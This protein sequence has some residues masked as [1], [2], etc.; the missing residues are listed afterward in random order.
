MDLEEARC[1]WD[2]E[3]SLILCHSFDR[4]WT[5]ILW[6]LFPLPTQKS[7]ANNNYNVVLCRERA[8]TKIG[9]DGWTRAEMTSNFPFYIFK[10]SHS[11]IPLRWQ[12]CIPHF[13]DSKPT[14]V[15]AHGRRSNFIEDWIPYM[16]L[17][18]RSRRNHK[19]VDFIRVCVCKRVLF[20]RI[21]WCAPPEN[22]FVGILIRWQEF[23]PVDLII[24]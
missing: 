23:S 19:C 7:I 3:I 6:N 15:S 20:C 8:E 14:P 18:I 21:F 11:V 4:V 13:R 5:D 12:N 22:M 1:N 17:K 2:M 24:F 10:V 16:L 9:R